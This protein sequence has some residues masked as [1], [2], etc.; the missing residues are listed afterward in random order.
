MPKKVYFKGDDGLYD[1]EREGLTKSQWYDRKRG[2][3]VAGSYTSAERAEAAKR[4]HKTR[5]GA[6]NAKAEAGNAK[7]G[8]AFDRE[9]VVTMESSSE[10]AQRAYDEIVRR[11]AIGEA[12]SEKTI[13][14]AAGVSSTPVRRA[15]ERFSAEQRQRDRDLTESEQAWLNRKLARVT[16]VLR[17]QITEEVRKE[18][19]EWYNERVR[20]PFEQELALARKIADASKGVFSQAELRLIISC[21]HPDNSAS[22]ARRAEAFRLVREKADVLAP[23]P[24]EVREAR[25]SPPLPKSFEEMMAGRRR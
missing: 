24:V 17:A 20:G 1:W 16:V 14:R 3:R 21:L 18:Y 4:G 6:G 2:R 10:Q 13:M 23:V 15:R 9:R 22:E 25:K 7:P 5:K 19:V 8:K 11:D 12:W